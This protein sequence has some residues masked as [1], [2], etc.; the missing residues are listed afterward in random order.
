MD[1][2]YLVLIKGEKM[3]AIDNRRKQPTFPLK[4]KLEAN[5]IMTAIT[6]KASHSN[7]LLRSR[8][9]PFIGAPS[10]MT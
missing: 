7:I 2:A 6:A 8:F 5:K 10:H 1:L 4:K 3:Q 9:V